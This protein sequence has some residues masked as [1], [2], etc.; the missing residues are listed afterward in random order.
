MSRRAPH[1]CTGRRRERLAK[2]LGEVE[3]VEPGQGCGPAVLFAAFCIVLMLLAGFS[4]W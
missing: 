1:R 3:V 2:P 4:P